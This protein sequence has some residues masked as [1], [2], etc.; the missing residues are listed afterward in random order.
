MLEYQDLLLRRLD[1]GLIG[2]ATF[3]CPGDR[4][5]SR[6]QTD[7]DL[8]ALEC[9]DESVYQRLTCLLCF[10]GHNSSFIFFLRVLFPLALTALGIFLE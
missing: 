7:G 4:L 9:G 2:V 10:F 6:D 3:D 5:T 1:Q 8:L